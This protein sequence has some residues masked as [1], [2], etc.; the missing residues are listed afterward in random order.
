MQW[1][2]PLEPCKRHED[3]KSKWLKDTGNWFLESTDF[4]AWCDGDVSIKNF[5][6]ILACYGIPGA[7]KSI[8]WYVS[9][10]SWQGMTRGYF[11]IQLMSHQ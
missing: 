9:F 11:E 3:I 2:S 4:K 6:P 7:G 8:M 10:Q 1:I 5:N